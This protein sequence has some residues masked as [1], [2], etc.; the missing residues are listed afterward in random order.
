MSPGR[1]PFAQL[2]TPIRALSARDSCGTQDP[3]DALFPV[4]RHHPLFTNTGLPT[5]DADVV[6]RRH[7]II[8]TVFADLIDGPLAHLPSGHF[9][10]NSAW[11]LCAAI[12]HNL[13][14]R[15]RHDRRRPPSPRPGRD[16]APT[17]DRRARPPGPTRSHT[18]AAPPQPLA[19]GP[20]MATAVEPD[21]RPPHRAQPARRCLTSTPP[22]TRPEHP[23]QWK[24][25][26][27][28]RLHTPPTP[29][30]QDHQ[31]KITVRLFCGSR[32]SR[33]NRWRG[34]VGTR[35]ATRERNV[36]RSFWTLSG[37]AGAVS[38][39]GVGVGLGDALGVLV[40]SSWSSWSGSAARGSRRRSAW[41]TGSRRRVR[42]LIG[43][44]GRAT[45]EETVSR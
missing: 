44:R 43:R 29:T 7:A 5:A 41:A 13:L 4:W 17:A 9:G 27:H 32:L 24:G 34:S 10:A 37:A 31:M 3:V 39:V 40:A 1:H 23:D 20:G 33:V 36:R 18:G 26:T 8:E 15:H 19:L 14:P 35:Q 6:H 45:Y 30:R 25:W 42:A 11:A 28:Q 16:P 21:H 22:A 12:A 38:T 2:K